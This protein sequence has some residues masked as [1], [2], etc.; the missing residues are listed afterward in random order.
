VLRCQAVK[1]GLRRAL[2]A[3]HLL[4]GAAVCASRWVR[5]WRLMICVRAAAHA[6]SLSQWLRV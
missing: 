1:R 5:T 4:H 6:R 3:Q 2:H